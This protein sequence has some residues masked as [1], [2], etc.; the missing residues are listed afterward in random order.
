MGTVLPANPFGFVSID[1]ENTLVTL[2]ANYFTLGEFE[3]A[4]GLF[5]SFES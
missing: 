2:L 3:L 4:R 1:N 5:Y